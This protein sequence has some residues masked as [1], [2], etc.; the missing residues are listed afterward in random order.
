MR[1]EAGALKRTIWRSRLPAT[2]LVDEVR[3]LTEARISADFR[4]AV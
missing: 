4:S 3:Q 2:R 1:A